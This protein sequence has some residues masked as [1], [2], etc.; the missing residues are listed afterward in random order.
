MLHC[1][2]S[3]PYFSAWVA[4]HETDL[5][6]AR[7]A[8]A[9]R[10][11]NALGEAMERSTMRMHACMMSAWPHSF[12]GS[13]APRAYRMCVGHAQSWYS[14]LFHPRC[15]KPHVKI[16]CEPKDRNTIIGNLADFDPNLTIHSDTIGP[17]LS[18]LHDAHC[19]PSTRKACSFW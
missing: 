2:E 6:A 13:L 1:E 16:L 11:I 9:T 14:M 3:S 18:C 17:G 7:N 4:Q 19:V 8:I 10:D 5:K 12:I 15:W